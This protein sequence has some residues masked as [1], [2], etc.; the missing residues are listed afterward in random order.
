[1]AYGIPLEAGGALLE[2]P[3]FYAHHPHV[4][5]I[6]ALFG[7]HPEVDMYNIEVLDCVYTAGQIIADSLVKQDDEGLK[8]VGWALAWLF[9]SS[10]NSLIDYDD[11]SLAEIP[12]L[13][14]DGNDVAFALELIGEAN[15]IIRD[16]NAG[17]QYF[18][19]HP[20]FLLVLHKNVEAIYASFNH[21]TRRRRNSKVQLHW[22]GFDKQLYLTVGIPHKRTK[23]SLLAAS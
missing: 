11:E 22:S 18:N 17:L 21:S 10:G 4:V 13:T 8:Q 6:L 3:D 9:S 20:P 14:W 2:D 5:P 23:F 12:P 7:I 16:V 1:M 19:L 15:G